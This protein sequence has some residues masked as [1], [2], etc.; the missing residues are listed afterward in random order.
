MKSLGRAWR[1]AEWLRSL[2]DESRDQQ[3]GCEVS[4]TSQ[5][6]SRKVVKS[7]GRIVSRKRHGTGSIAAKSIGRVWRTA[8]QLFSL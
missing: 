4:R 1:P 6:I 2:L 7:L 5:Y 3:D 8:G